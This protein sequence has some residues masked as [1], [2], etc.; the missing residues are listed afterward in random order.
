VVRFFK[1][2]DI[3][4][5]HSWH[6][7]SDFSEP[8]AARLAG[9]KFVFTKKNMGWGNKAWVLKSKMSHQV[10]AINQ[11]MMKVFFNSITAINAKYLPLGIDTEYYKPKV[12][13]LNL[14]NQLGIK[15]T[16]FVL[17]SVANLVPLKGIENL[18]K[19]FQ[20]LSV[21][22]AKLLI[23]GNNQ[24]DYGKSLMNN[25]QDENIIFTGKQ[26]DV[27]PFLSLADVFCIPTLSIGEG[28]PLATVEAMSMGVPV[29][30][31]K[32]SG[33]TD[34]LTGFEEWIF[35]VDN[36]QE[37][38]Q[39]LKNINELTSE[40]RVHLGRRMRNKVLSVYSFN[41]FILSRE[42]LYKLIIE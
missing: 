26:I 41:H 42:K 2:L 32:V 15:K 18:I 39:K 36:E 17:I 35:E 34:V 6:W 9:I 3:D 31:S 21:S 20:K 27:R 22:N 25:Y 28:M 11:D 7:S 23:V 19:A 14:A 37:L 16:D 29:I 40:E 38:A 12:F 1:G 24:N 8:L 33:I 13:D 4:I 5:I 10:I 30:G